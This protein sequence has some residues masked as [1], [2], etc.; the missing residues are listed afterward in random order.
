MPLVGEVPPPPPAKSSTPSRARSKSSPKLADI[1]PSNKAART[2]TLLGLA[3]IGQGVCLMLGQYADA[4]TIDMYG[5][6]FLSA[7]AELGDVHPSFGESIDKADGI[8]PYFALF[9][10][11]VP[12]AL[13]FMANHNRIDASKVS[14]GGLKDPSVLHNRQ[15]AKVMNAQAAMMAERVQAEQDARAAEAA[16][17]HQADAMRTLMEPVNAEAA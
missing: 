3:G 16:M 5:R 17:H 12:M 11:A 4:E 8:G 9:A 14:F 13:Q 15:A 7:V 10:A 6:P 2:E 1:K